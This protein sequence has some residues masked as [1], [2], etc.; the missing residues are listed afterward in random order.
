MKKK[1]LV[2]L[3]VL[4]FLYCIGGV[5]YSIVVSQNN[6]NENI[7]SKFNFYYL[8]VLNED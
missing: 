8:G 2:V 5:I 3:L 7:V 1:I 4:I 6:T